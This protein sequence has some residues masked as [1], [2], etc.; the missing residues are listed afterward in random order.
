MTYMY[1][2]RLLVLFQKVFSEDDVR[3]DVVFL[4]IIGIFWSQKN[5]FF[6]TMMRKNLL[7]STFLPLRAGR[8]KCWRT[9]LCHLEIVK[10]RGRDLSFLPRQWCRGG[11]YTVY[12]SEATQKCKNIFSCF[13]L[14][15]FMNHK[16]PPILLHI[17]SEDIGHF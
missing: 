5:L 15:R 14:S 3:Y 7:W 2:Q 9:F 8:K 16:L 6:V 10:R 17:L 4:I 13:P 11:V 1:L 12:Q